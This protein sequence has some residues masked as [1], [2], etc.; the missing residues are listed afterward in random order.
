MRKINLKFSMVLYYILLFYAETFSVPSHSLDLCFESK[1]IIF[2][3]FWLVLRPLPCIRAQETKM[4]R[5]QL[6]LMLR[7][8]G[9]NVISMIDLGD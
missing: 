6:V 3:M 2:S 8:L 5:I 4:L 1:K 9:L 7:P